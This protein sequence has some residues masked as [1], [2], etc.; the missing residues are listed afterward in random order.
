M[1]DDGG[2]VRVVEVVR[3]EDGRIGVAVVVPDDQLEPLAVDAAGRVDLFRGELGGLP[4]R[5]ANRIAERAGH[6][7]ANDVVA[8]RWHPAASAAATSRAPSRGAN[9][10]KRSDNAKARSRDRWSSSKSVEGEV[11][12]DAEEV[13]KCGLEQA[14]RA[15]VLPGGTGRSAN[16]V[17]TSDGTRCWTGPIVRPRPRSTCTARP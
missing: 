5:K 3:D 13:E 16:Y 4:H 10:L 6:A 15:P 7:D 11:L 1:P 8:V 17:L 14:V 12:A 2:D 9:S